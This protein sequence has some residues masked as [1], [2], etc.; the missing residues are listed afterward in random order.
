VSKWIDLE[1]T[2]YMRTFSRLPVVLVRGEGTR[3]WDEDGKSYLDMVAGI[4]VNVLGHAHPALVKAIS[5]QASKLIHTS[6]L[7]Y[8]I[9]QLELAELIVDNT[10][11]DQ[12]FY[13]NSGAE[14]NE[15]AI[16][17]ARKWGKLNRDGAYHI[18]STTN[19]FHGRTLATVAATGQPKLQ[20]NFMPMPS[21][22]SSVP[23]NDLAALKEATNRE[24]CAILL[25]VVQGESGVNIGDQDYIRGVR[26]WC[27]EQNVLF[28]L[29]E[30]QTGIGRTGRFMGYENYGVEPDVFTLAKGLAGGVP[31]G[32]IVAKERAA[33]FTPSDH[34]S[35]FGGNP[36]ACAAG[37]ATVRTVREAGLVENSA[38][39]GAYLL[40]KLKDLQSRQP[41]IVATRG[42]GLMIA[43][44]LRDEVAPNV[45]KA[46]LANGMILNNTSAKTVRMVPPLILNQADADEAV[47]ILE[48]SFAS[49]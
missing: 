32:A 19:S 22:F 13:V 36:L 34:G 24:T 8:T 46:A 42:V 25:E 3:V 1:R 47:S 37:V 7:Y 26:A 21:G 9:P 33:V 5:E 4:A 43:V 31:I 23:F 15:G 27:D 6:N 35:T 20:T 49:L 12:I 48:Q 16:K 40:G 11:G 30:I 38:K 14:A 18:V 2:Y 39:T 10:V 29:D 17:L 45:V 41:Q 44:D 28:M